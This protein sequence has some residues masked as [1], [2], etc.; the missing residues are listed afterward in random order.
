MKTTSRRQAVLDGTCQPQPVQRVMIPR[1]VG[2]ERALGIPTVTD[3]PIWQAIAQIMGPLFDVEI[4]KVLAVVSQGAA[5]L[6]P[7]G[8]PIAVDGIECT[9]DAVRRQ[10]NHGVFDHRLG[11][12]AALIRG[13]DCR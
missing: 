13:R 9:V 11:I 12:D 10:A 1:P 4:H 7:G 8:E 2:G 5:G 3:R 6:E